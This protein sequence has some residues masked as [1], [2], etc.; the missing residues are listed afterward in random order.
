MDFLVGGL[1]RGG[2]TASARLLNKSDDTFCYAAETHLI[3][4]I[5]EFV[6]A[7]PARHDKIELFMDTL[8]KQNVHVLMEMVDFNVARG[9]SREYLLFDTAAIQDLETHVRDVLLNGLFGAD[10]IISVMNKVSEIIGKKTG[11]GIIGEKSPPNTLSFQLLPELSV[12]PSIH[13]VREPFSSFISSANRAKDTDDKFNSGFSVELLQNIG[14]Y[15]EYADAMLT[16]SGF[17]NTHIFKYENACLDIGRYVADITSALGL[18]ISDQGLEQAK[19]MFQT[20]E[21]LSQISRFTEI[22]I[23]QTVGILRQ[24]LPELGYDQAFFLEQGKNID[25]LIIGNSD[26]ETGLWPLYG[27]IRDNLNRMIITK[28]RAKL[29]LMAEKSVRGIKLDVFPVDLKKVIGLNGPAYV[30]S[31]VEGRLVNQHELSNR[32]GT[33][34]IDIS[35]DDWFPIGTRYKQAVLDLRA[36]FLHRPSTDEAVSHDRTARCFAITSHRYI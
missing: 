32:G 9:A 1:P 8:H 23:G 25:N 29:A 10:A 21:Q 26:L 28:R 34:T 35:E 11:K 15:L 19:R 20:R 31:F 12:I 4:L 36:N 27:A 22:D 17:P 5:E 13:I 30:D 3:T 6:G 7:R 18:R 2:T 33:I 14:M 24:V 16:I